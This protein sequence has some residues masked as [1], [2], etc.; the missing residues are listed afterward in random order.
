[1]AESKSQKKERRKEARKKRSFLGRVVHDYIIPVAVILVVMTPIRASVTDWNDVPSG[2]MR[3]TILEG[4][5]IVVNKLAY[6]VRVPLTH[7]WITHFDGPQRGDIVT[8]ASPTDGTRMVKRVIGLPGDR[9]SMR[10][11]RLMINGKTVLYAG[12]EEDGERIEL[13]P[14]GR[15]VRVLHEIERFGD[16]AHAIAITPSEASPR[17]FDEVIVPADAYLVM[18]DNRDQSLDSRSYGFVSRD[19]IY[20]RVSRVAL[21]L[22]PTNSYMPRFARW[23]MRLD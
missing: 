15:R 6:G 5:R 2:S 3:P 4:D 8:L 17:S 10:S 19:Y 14:S 11:N 20:G 23:F 12:V 9:V 7:R 18:G 16:R 13:H 21:S 22:D 1:M